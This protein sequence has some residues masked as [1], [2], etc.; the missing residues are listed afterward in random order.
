MQTAT[1]TKIP[2]CAQISLFL[3]LVEHFATKNNVFTTPIHNIQALL[4]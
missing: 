4:W 3:P 1:G 2:V